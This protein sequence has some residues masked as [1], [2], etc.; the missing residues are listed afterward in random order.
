MGFNDGG[1]PGLI[2]VLFCV[3]LLHLS[4][5][6]SVTIYHELR[7]QHLERGDWFQGNAD[8]VDRSR[9][10][11]NTETNERTDVD[12]IRHIVREI[13]EFMKADD[14]DRARKLRQAASPGT[15]GNEMAQIFEQLANS[16]LAIFNKYCGQ[17]STICL[18]GPKGEKGNQGLAGTPG[19]KGTSG[20]PGEKG[21]KGDVG[22]PGFQGQK[23]DPGNIGFPGVKGDKG[24]LGS[25]GLSGPAGVKG[26]RGNIGSQ[27]P[28]GKDGAPGLQGTKGEK[29]RVGDPGL[30]GG[31][32][33]RGDYGPPGIPGAKGAAGFPGL[34]GD[35]GDSGLSGPPGPP[36]VSGQK[37]DPGTEG[38]RG[39]QGEKG[40]VGPKGD[41]GN[42]ALV[43]PKATCCDSLEKPYF[44]QTTQVIN[45]LE[46]SSVTLHC[47]VQ[48]HPKPTREWIHVTV[49]TN[50]TVSAVSSAESLTLVN[51]DPYRDG[52]TYT[53]KGSSALGDATK[54]VQLNVYQHIRIVDH[55]SNH[56]MLVGQ[57][58][59]FECKFQSEPKPTV[60][61]YHVD[62][63]GAR[64][65]ITTGVIEIPGGTQLELPAVG[66][67]D[68]G[69]Y[70]CVA[71]NGLETV[72]QHAFLVTQGPPMISPHAP[73][74]GLVGHTLKLHCDVTGD[75]KPTTTWIAPPNVNNAYEDKNGDLVLLNTQAG[76][77]GPYICKA[78]NSFGSANSVVTLVVHEPGKVEI[79]GSH[80]IP[81]GA[82]TT[83]FAIACKASGEAPLNV[84]WY[85]DG[86]PVK[87]DSF[88]ALL[89]DNTLLILSVNRPADY[90]RYSCVASNL[91]GSDNSTATV[92]EDKGTTTCD[93][94]FTDCS[95]KICGVKCPPGC[96]QTAVD[97]TTSYSTSAPLCLS[98]I[99][100][101]VIQNN[102][103]V[104]TWQTAGNTATIQT[105]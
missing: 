6:V 45:A 68:K 84:Q 61:W 20:L 24:E 4:A 55:I 77:A 64:T 13:T 26:E 14:S 76:D 80:L 28:A 74:T 44:N 59:V 39:L 93:A 10:R 34:K 19:L 50:G 2:G 65:Q 47:D 56:S 73:V 51:L 72:S 41:P 43:T 82:L 1:H 87:P 66:N 16:E 38:L 48:G 103:G 17:N 5:F 78:T 67:K 88:H 27:G 69:E 71:N 37:G 94:P 58:V 40:D 25:P 98:G 97:G 3:G 70:T 33:E 12:V 42:T 63:N 9:Q 8:D 105:Q 23:G 95:G 83:N 32:G 52:G 49:P 21:A 91:Y 85:H 89:P 18:P 96:Q 102:G 79:P 104:V 11:R 90:G 57:N 53:C 60:T 81:V 100:S 35:K 99:Q 31:K 86:S 7:I 101:G 22:S 62:Q 36:G 92:Y 29:G 54:I 30:K 15:T 46:G 75:P